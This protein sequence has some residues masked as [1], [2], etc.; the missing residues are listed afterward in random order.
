MRKTA[1]A[2]LMALLLLIA[3]NVSSS[4]AAP[5]E[6][7]IGLN[8]GYPYTLLE[9]EFEY[10]NGPW[11]GGTDVAWAGGAMEMGIFGRYYVPLGLGFDFYAAVNPGMVIVF[12]SVPPSV[13]GTIKV[14]PGFDFKWEHLRVGLEGGMLYIFGHTTPNFYIKG[15]LGVL[16]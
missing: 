14:G 11:A 15:G 4:A 5:N 7:M 13:K 3:F 8:S 1:I 6:F 16:F 2:I 9:L 12:S 10:K